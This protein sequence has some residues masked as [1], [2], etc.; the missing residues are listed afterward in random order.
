MQKV[1]GNTGTNPWNL[2]I[3]VS[4]LIKGP[5]LRLIAT[6]SYTK[7]LTQ[8]ATTMALSNIGTNSIQLGAQAIFF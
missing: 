5:A 4:Y 8:D 1:K 7:L 6:Y 2:E 3:A